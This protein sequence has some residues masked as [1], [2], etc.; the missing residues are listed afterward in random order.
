RSRSLHAAYLGLLTVE[1][2]I[3]LSEAIRAGRSAFR[4]H[5]S[6]SND[7]DDNLGIRGQMDQVCRGA[8]RRG[9]QTGTRPLNPSFY[10]ML[11]GVDALLEIVYG[12]PGC[13]EES[14]LIFALADQ[15]LCGKVCALA[16]TL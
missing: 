12:R 1:V 15:R 8:K 3:G 2:P 13:S 16:T 10:F 6:G 9:F 5:T 4:R 14:R 7:Q 11:Q